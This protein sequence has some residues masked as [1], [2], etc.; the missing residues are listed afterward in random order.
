ME[1]VKLRQL[2]TELDEAIKRVENMQKKTQ[3]M[4]LSSRIRQ[5]VDKHGSVL[6]NVLLA[7]AACILA[8]QKMQLKHELEVCV[9][10]VLAKATFGTR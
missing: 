5:H 4:P 1:D 6:V 10:S 3:T 7:G 2:A 9:H 8:F